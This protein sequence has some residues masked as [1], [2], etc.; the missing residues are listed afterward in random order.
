MATTPKLTRYVELIKNLFPRGLVWQFLEQ[1][2]ISSEIQATAT[3]FCRVDDRAEK[4]ID[5][6]AD[7]RI[8]DETLEQWETMVGL[9]DECTPEGITVEERRNAVVQ[10]LTIEGS[11]SKNFYEKIGDDLGFD[12]TVEPRLPFRA[13]LSR[14]GDAL[15]NNK[16][17]IFRAGDRA[18]TALREW[19]WQYY[20]NVDQPATSITE[21][22]AGFGRAGDPLVTFSNPLLECTIRKLKPAHAGVTF[23]FS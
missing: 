8:A 15:Y 6:E 7:P 21:F 11:L 19:G 3:E 17:E 12:I 5:V 13:G 9:P 20:F 4:L 10:R 1:P 23:T 16:N 22:R 18:G 2:T 14:A